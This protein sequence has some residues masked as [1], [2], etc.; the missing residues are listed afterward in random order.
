MGLSM[1]EN[2]KMISKMGTELNHTKLARN[3]KGYSNRV[4]NM[5]GLSTIKTKSP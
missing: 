3:S 2:L 4:R 5:K 1:R